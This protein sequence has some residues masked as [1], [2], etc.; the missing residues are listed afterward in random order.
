MSSYFLIPSLSSMSDSDWSIDPEDEPSD[1][2][3]AQQM[4]GYEEREEQSPVG[5]YGNQMGAEPDHAPRTPRA[6]AAPRC[7][8]AVS[9]RYRGRR[10]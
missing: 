7:P 9:H 6:R 3:H 2:I 4:P 8:L 10:G 5:M 1:S